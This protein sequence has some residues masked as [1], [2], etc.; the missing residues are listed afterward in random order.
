MT[1]SAVPR[2]READGCA[3]VRGLVGLARPTRAAEVTLV[4]ADAAV[5]FTGALIGHTPLFSSSSASSASSAGSAA[6]W[7]TSPLGDTSVAGTFGVGVRDVSP[8]PVAV[9]LALVLR[10]VLELELAGGVTEGRGVV[11]GFSAAAAAAAAAA[12]RLR[13]RSQCACLCS[14][15]RH[16]LRPARPPG[17]YVPSAARL[18]DDGGSGHLSTS[19]RFSFSF[20]FSFS[21][22]LSFCFSFFSLSKAML[23]DTFASGVWRD[24]GT[25]GAETAA[26]GTDT[27]AVAVMTTAAGAADGCERGEDDTAALL[28]LLLL[29]LIT[30]V[31]GTYIVNV[32]IARPRRGCIAPLFALRTVRKGGCVLGLKLRLLL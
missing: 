15:R 23:I 12:A 8:D 22:D 18:R 29:V 7:H 17:R 10:P 13:R 20:S 21:L 32:R 9:E 14:S 11:A 2:V 25:V 1:G 30:A 24:G 28:V 3:Y 26:A 16:C 31:R 19:L 27:T 4:I 6:A 5:A